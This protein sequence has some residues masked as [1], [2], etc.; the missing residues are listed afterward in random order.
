MRVLIALQLLVIVVAGA[1]TVARFPVFALVDE[2][3]HYDYVQK[4]ADEGRLPWL[5][6]DLISS[7]AEALSEGVY[8]APPRLDPATRGLAGQSYEAFQPPL[9]YGLAAPAFLAAG[10]DHGLKLRVLRGVG[11]LALLAAAGLLW[12]LS[13]RVAGRARAPAVYA[14]ALTVLMWPGVVVRTVTVSNAALELV[15]GVAAAVALW[16]ARSSRRWLLGAG[17]LV[18]L[19]LLTRSTFAVFVPWLLWVA[20]GHALRPALIAVVVPVVMLAPWLASNVDR[21][22]ALTGSAIVREMQEPFL[23]PSGRDYGVGD[24][25]ERAPALLNGVL[26]EEWWSEFLPA[27]KRRLRDVVMALLFAVPVGLALWRRRSGSSAR[28]WLLAAPLGIGLVL[29]AAGLLVGNW[30]FFYPRYLYATLP[31]FGVFAALALPRRAAPAAAATIT[32]ALAGLWAYLSTV[33]P[34]TP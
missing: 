16:E 11:W 2:L 19:G 29:M 17:V 6:R 8:P 13:L 30:D 26:A 27:W 31:A 7:E 32:V 10:G 34:F 24:V 4:V 33:V 21:Y 28:E 18:G 5:G 25:F 20:R 14:V 9:Y 22:G 12:L 15:L 23:N 1:A 3:A